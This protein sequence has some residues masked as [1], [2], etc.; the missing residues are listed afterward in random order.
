M[1]V[2]G[3]A[4]KFP[5][6]EGGILIYIYSFFN[7]DL[8]IWMYTWNHKWIHALKFVYIKI[9]TNFCSK[10]LEGLSRH[11]LPSFIRSMNRL[12]E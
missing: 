3:A 1:S 5:P 8:I 10:G 9:K 4:T 2:E 7:L 12:A 11:P 6:L